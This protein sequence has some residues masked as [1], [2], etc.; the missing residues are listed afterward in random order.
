MMTNWKMNSSNFD[1]II[2]KCCTFDIKKLF[3]QL[4]EGLVGL[5]ESW[6]ESI[7]TCLR[8][9]TEAFLLFLAPEEGSNPAGPIF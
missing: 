8:F 7:V 4:K 6:I 9:I 1:K 2:I 3:N 5:F